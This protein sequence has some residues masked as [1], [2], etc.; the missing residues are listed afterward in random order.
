MPRGVYPRTR[1]AKSPVSRTCQYCGIEFL[2][3]PSRIAQWGAKFCSRR[4]SS[5]GRT[6][7]VGCVRAKSVRPLIERLLSRVN[8]DG[9]LSEARPDL[10]PCWVWMRK[11]HH[12][13]YAHAPD[14]EGR[15]AQ[16]HR[17]VYR[18]LVG[19]IPDGL[20]LDHLCRVRHC[21]RPSHLEP[22]TQAVNLLRG[23]GVCAKNARKTHCKR[24]HPFDVVNTIITKN[25]RT[26]R[27]CINA[28][29]QQYRDEKR[30]KKDV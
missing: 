30:R 22:V 15:T 26:C 29:H 8:Q 3:K 2:A 6:Y 17:L 10:G 27:T 24:G 23:E 18:E 19:P 14:A 11:L 4:C 9:P 21:C 5:L 13:G 7:P 20:Q 1:T 16:V 12:G 28:Y 25:G